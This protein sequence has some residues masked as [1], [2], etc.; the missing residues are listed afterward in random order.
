MGADIGRIEGFIVEAVG[1]DF[2]ANFDGEFV[3]GFAA[4][5]DGDFEGNVGEKGV[6]IQCSAEFVEVCGGHGHLGVDAFVSEVDAA[7]NAEL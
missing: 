1:D 7:E 5:F 4:V 6:F 3:E 2:F